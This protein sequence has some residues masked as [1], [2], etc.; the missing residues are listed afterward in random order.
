MVN[1]K[2]LGYV[3][4]LFFFLR[5]YGPEAAYDATTTWFDSYSLYIY[6]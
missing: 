3:R 6:I 4:N 1:N 2:T 5:G